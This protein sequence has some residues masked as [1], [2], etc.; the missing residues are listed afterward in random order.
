M[1]IV[2]KVSYNMPPVTKKAR[3]EKKTSAAASPLSRDSVVLVDAE[4][5]QLNTGDVGSGTLSTGRAEI[6][7]YRDAVDS[8]VP[9]CAD[10]QRG[11]VSPRLSRS[12]GEECQL[13]CRARRNKKYA[14]IN[15]PSADVV[16]ALSRVSDDNPGALFVWED[17]NCKAF[18]V[19]LN[20]QPAILIPA[21]LGP[22]PITLA[23]LKR[24]LLTKINADAGGGGVVN[25][26]LIAPN[27]FQQYAKIQTM[28]A[29]L[30]GSSAFPLLAVLPPFP[31][32]ICRMYALANKAART[33]GIS[34]P[35]LVPVAPDRGLFQ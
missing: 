22:L 19:Q 34:D 27:T 29:C 25:S 2:G 13:S 14:I 8:T 6:Q 9:R 28:C 7:R 21:W 33:T 16:K 20:L 18:L 15:N 30:G 26:C 10:A 11:L 3:L 31:L 35:V 17:D 4:A 24:N 5:L 12:K 1:T 32:P 23:Q